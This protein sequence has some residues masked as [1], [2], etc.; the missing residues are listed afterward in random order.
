MIDA[1]LSSSLRI[2]TPGPPTTD[3]TPRL[4]ANPVENRRAA[5]SAA[6]HSVQLTDGLG[7]DVDD[8]V[9]LVGGDRQRRHEHDDVAQRTQQDTAG[10]R[11][12]ARPPAPP[13][14]LARRVELDA[15]HQ[16]LEADIA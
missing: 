10:H 1:W 3:S 4:A 15:A 6:A 7:Q 14:P 8:A 2:V 11:R 13:Q 12:R 16:A 9:D 5:P